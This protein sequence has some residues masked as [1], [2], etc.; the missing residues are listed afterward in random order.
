MEVTLSA[1][2]YDALVQSAHEWAVKAAQAAATCEVLLIA[3]VV[4]LAVIVGVFVGWIVIHRWS[5]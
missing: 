3:I 2:Q 1:I 4:L 5:V